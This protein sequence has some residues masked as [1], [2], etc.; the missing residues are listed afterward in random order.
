MIAN[1]LLSR[2]EWEAKLRR[3]GAEPLQG[4]SS[5]NSGEWWHVPNRYPFKVPVE[6][7]EGRCEFWA[8]QRIANDLDKPLPPN[9]FKP[10]SH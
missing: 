3:C 4:K 9:P 7:D 10:V 8:I 5:N 2:A 6:D 1:R